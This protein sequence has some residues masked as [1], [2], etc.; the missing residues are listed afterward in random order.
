MCRHLGRK[1]CSIVKIFSVGR[2]KLTDLED[3]EFIPIAALSQVKQHGLPYG[4]DDWNHVELIVS[5]FT[6]TNRSS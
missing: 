1:V 6:I 3:I 5:K 2:N 4:N